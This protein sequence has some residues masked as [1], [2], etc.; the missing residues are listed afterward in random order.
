M[1]LPGE[2][3][4]NLASYNFDFYGTRSHSP[5][6]SR[7]GSQKQFASMKP[8]S[9]LIS[10]FTVLVWW[11]DDGSILEPEPVARKS[12]TSTFCMNDNWTE[13]YI[14]ES[15][16][17]HLLYNRQPQD[18]ALSR[19]RPVRHIFSTILLS[20]IA[21]K[22]NTRQS[23]FLTSSPS[24]QLPRNTPFSLCTPYATLV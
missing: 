9:T 21:C 18:V 10:I 11:P 8:E 2:C 4:I 17:H 22:N 14:C 19:S 3:W 13:T 1:R 5:A 16:L 24:T 7:S 15:T 6:N 12:F 23:Q 20:S